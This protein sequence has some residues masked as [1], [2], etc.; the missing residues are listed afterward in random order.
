MSGRELAKRVAGPCVR[1]RGT[2]FLAEDTEVPGQA[3]DDPGPPVL[4]LP[5]P[6][7]SAALLTAVRAGL[8]A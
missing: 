6:F 2:L 8:D 3:I 5:K 7:G 4:T 1:L